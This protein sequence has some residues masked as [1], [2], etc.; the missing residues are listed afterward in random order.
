MTLEGPYTLHRLQQLPQELRR[1][2]SLRLRDLLGRSLRHDL[3]A[4]VAAFGA[5]VDDVVGGFDDVEVVFDH[6]HRVA[7]VDQAVEAF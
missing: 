2:R 4:F 5:E 1:M 6:Q 3:A 7:V